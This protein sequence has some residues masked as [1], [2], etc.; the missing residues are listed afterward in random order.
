MAGGFFELDDAPESDPVRQRLVTMELEFRQLLIGM[1]NDAVERGEL[2]TDLDVP[3]F[4]WEMCGLYLNHHV[5]HRFI[6]DPRDQACAP[7]VR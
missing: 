4:V 2:K 7:R 5:S 1:T 3:R 6:H